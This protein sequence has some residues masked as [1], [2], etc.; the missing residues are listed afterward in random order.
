MQR[1]TAEHMLLSSAAAFAVSH[2]ACVTDTD[3]TYTGSSHA[4]SGA[5]SALFFCA[6]GLLFMTE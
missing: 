6:E 3:G 4:A 2:S 5:Y 1:I